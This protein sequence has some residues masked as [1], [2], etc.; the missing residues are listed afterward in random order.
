VPCRAVPCRAVPCRAVP[1]RAV[2]CRA[3]PCRA[4]KGSP[5]PRRDQGSKQPETVKP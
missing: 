1:C 3:V 5:A 4:E 2:P